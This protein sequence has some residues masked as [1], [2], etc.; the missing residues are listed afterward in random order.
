M[1]LLLLLKL[2]ED[3]LV[4]VTP[5]SLVLGLELGRELL[6]VVDLVVVLVELRPDAALEGR[7]HEILGSETFVLRSNEGGAVAEWSKALLQR[8]R[9]NEKPK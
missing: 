1:T 3:L 5:E 8:E 2:A 7:C 6:Q 4:D 9:I